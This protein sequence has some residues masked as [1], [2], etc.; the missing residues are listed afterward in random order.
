LTTARI[1]AAMTSHTTDIGR[2]APIDASKILAIRSSNARALMSAAAAS[3]S[4]VDVNLHHDGSDAISIRWTFEWK[5]S[6]IDRRRAVSIG[7]RAASD[8]HVFD[9]TQ[10]TIISTLNRRCRIFT[11]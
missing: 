4:T 2:R 1:V 6:R 11:A 9:R 10:S 7:D 5:M 3:R 8:S